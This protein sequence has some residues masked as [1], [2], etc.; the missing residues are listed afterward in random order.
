M[1]ELVIGWLLK[2]QNHKMFANQDIMTITGFMT[3]TQEVYDHYI[4]CYNQTLNAA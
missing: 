3:T 1:R 2:V 4:R